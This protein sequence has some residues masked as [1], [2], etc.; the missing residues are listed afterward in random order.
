MNANT[1]ADELEQDDKFGASDKLK[2]AATMLRQQQEELAELRHINR[3][4]QIS[5]H[6]LLIEIDSQKNLINKLYGIA[7]WLQDQRPDV[8]EDMRQW[9][10][11]EKAE[12]EN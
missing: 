12:N 6:Q 9:V 2:E 7:N 11:N 4:W 1:L 5:E 3:N 10:K 8:W